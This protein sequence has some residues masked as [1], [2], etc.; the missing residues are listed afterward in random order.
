[1]HSITIIHLNDIGI[2]IRANET[3]AKLFLFARDNK[4]L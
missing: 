4:T 1:M 3:N 2:R